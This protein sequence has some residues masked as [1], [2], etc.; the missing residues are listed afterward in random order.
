[1]N[2]RSTVKNFLTF[3]YTAY[4]KKQIGSYKEGLHVN[5]RSKFTRNTH[6][7][8]NCH[9]NGILISGSGKV[10]IGDN[11]H[12]GKRIRIITSNHN[13]EG[14]KIPYDETMITKDVTIED[15]V[16][17]GEDVLILAG[18]TIGEGAIIQAGSVVVKSIPP[19]SIAGGAPAIVFKKRNVEHYNK[20]KEEKKF[21]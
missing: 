2:L 14:S 19:Y 16:W 1:M 5:F 12:S 11:F 8:N 3:M 9:F 4:A 7:G 10:T 21:F 17:L 6:I 18:V 15:N 20:L 13:Y